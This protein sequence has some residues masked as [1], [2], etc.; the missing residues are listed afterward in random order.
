MSLEIKRP[1]LGTLRLR[2]VREPCQTDRMR[3]KLQVW[4]VQ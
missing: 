2:Q 3:T 4:W 1:M